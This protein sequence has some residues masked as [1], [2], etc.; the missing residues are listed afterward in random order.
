MKLQGVT[1]GYLG[2]QKATRSYRELEGVTG[3]VSWG[4]EGLQEVTVG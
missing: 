4:Y 3:S 1:G 2:L